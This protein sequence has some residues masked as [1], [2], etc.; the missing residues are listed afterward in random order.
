MLRYLSTRNGASPVVLRTTNPNMI[1]AQEKACRAKAEQLFFDPVGNDRM[2]YGV[3]NNA[4][5][6]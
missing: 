4:T 3:K 2:W 5:L 1:K 6:D